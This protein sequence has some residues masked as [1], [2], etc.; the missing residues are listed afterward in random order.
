MINDE[1]RKLLIIN[2]LR[3]IKSPY[4]IHTLSLIKILIYFESKSNDKRVILIFVEK[5]LIFCLGY[6]LFFTCKNAKE[7]PS[8]F[9]AFTNKI[10]LLHPCRVHLNQPPFT[11]YFLQ[12]NAFQPMNINGFIGFSIGQ[13][14]V[15]VI[16]YPRHF[17]SKIKFYKI[18]TVGAYPLFG[19]ALG[20]FDVVA[21]GIHIPNFAYVI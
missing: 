9:F 13:M 7:G 2:C 17:S 11:F 12:N 4:I 5:I 18:K 3:K 1:F 10:Q 21:N 15:I 20:C 19:L 8:V 14:S 6:V 16:A